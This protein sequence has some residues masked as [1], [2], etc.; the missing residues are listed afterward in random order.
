M[1]PCRRVIVS[2]LTLIA[3][4]ALGVPAHAAPA[5]FA[6][7]A[8]IFATNNTAIITDPQDPRLR[9]KLVMFGAQ[10]TVMICQA[11]AVP[12]G[13]RL[14][15]GVF[16]SNQLRQATYEPSREFHVARISSDELH[17]L[18][19]L[20]ARRYHQESVLT[21]RYLPGDSARADGI[22]V[23]VPGV[24]VRRLYDGLAADPAARASFGGGSVTESGHL[25]LVA[26]RAD[27]ALLRG[28]VT[29][30]GADWAAATIRSG[31]LEFVPAEVQPS[32]PAVA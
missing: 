22:E 1:S 5:W 24:D 16:W 28:F 17:H 31:T 32:L 10:V 30:I 23:E 12:S 29:T 7:E 13:S 8:E 21:F 9:S 20:I 19:G 14:L 26:Q 4:I 6:P 15:A 25:I 27:L 11:G 3:F 18:A 2:V